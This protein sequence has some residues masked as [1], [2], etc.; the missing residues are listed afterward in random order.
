MTKD[1][2]IAK[3]MLNFEDDAEQENYIAVQNSI[4]NAMK[5]GN[6][7]ETFYKE[8]FKNERE[9]SRLMLDSTKRHLEEDGFEVIDWNNYDTWMVIW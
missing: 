1:E 2:M 3:F 4:K 6:R 7:C 9:P 5:Q 8:K